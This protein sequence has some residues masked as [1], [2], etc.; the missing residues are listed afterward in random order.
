LGIGL[1]DLIQHFVHLVAVAGGRLVQDV[2]PEVCLTDTQCKI[3]LLR[4]YSVGSTEGDAVT[5]SLRACALLWLG[6]LPFLRFSSP[7]GFGS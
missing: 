6:V 3:K 5:T 2:P 4:V 7:L 1:Q